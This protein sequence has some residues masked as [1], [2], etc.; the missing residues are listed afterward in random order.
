M[1]LR[2]FI[3]QSLVELMGGLADAQQQL[4]ASQVYATVCPSFSNA[5]SPAGHQTTLG[6]STYGRMISL[7]EFDVAVEATAETDA[8]GGIK[9]LGGIF[10]A[11]A[12]GKMKDVDKV[13]SRIKFNVPVVYLEVADSPPREA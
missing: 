9:V 7:V 1:E 6:K 8:G 5:I 4:R 3:S 10:G 13:V 12:G 2:K 11:E